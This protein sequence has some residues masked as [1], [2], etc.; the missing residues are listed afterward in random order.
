[1]NISMNIPAKKLKGK[2][3]KP[4]D[5]TYLTELDEQFVED[6]KNIESSTQFAGFLETWN[7][8]LD[9]ESKKLEGKDWSR[10]ASLLTDCRKEGVIPED[11]HMP[12]IALAMPEKITKVSLIKIKFMVPWGCAYKRLREDGLID[13]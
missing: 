3:M 2:F 8:W 6:L 7:Y 12:A 4:E 11:K 13:F 9:D 1:M 5:V 10:M